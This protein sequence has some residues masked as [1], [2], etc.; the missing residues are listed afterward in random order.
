MKYSELKKG[1]EFWFS[2]MD[3]R[4]KGC[5][6]ISDDRYRRPDTRF[7]KLIE[8]DPP[9]NTKRNPIQESIARSVK[10]DPLI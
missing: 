2:D 3:V 8:G 4:K 10:E 5:K 7:P 6:K 9:V 1:T